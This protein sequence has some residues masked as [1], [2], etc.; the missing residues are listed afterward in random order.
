MRGG[1]RRSLLAIDPGADAGKMLQQHFLLSA[2]QDK[3]QHGQCFRLHG[4]GKNARGCNLPRNWLPA[5][6]IEDVGMAAASSFLPL[7]APVSGNGG[8]G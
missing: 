3:E 8:T 6:R 5:P 1:S 4:G 7:V 2:V